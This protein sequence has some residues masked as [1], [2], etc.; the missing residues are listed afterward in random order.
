M[1]KETKQFLRE[2]RR[3]AGV[4]KN[5][6]PINYSVNDPVVYTTKV[7]TDREIIDAKSR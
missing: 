5:G 3:N 4:D 7:M 2:I 1:S 6:K